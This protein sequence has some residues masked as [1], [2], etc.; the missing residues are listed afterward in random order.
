MSYTQ[1]REH[2]LF[3][4]QSTRDV[5]DVGVEFLTDSVSNSLYKV[6]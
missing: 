6:E 1:G 3:A 5:A 2:T 4:V